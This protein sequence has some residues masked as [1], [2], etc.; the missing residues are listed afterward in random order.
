M[1]SHI[2]KVIE[3]NSFIL[4][5]LRS[6]RKAAQRL[7]RQ[8]LKL[9]CGAIFCFDSSTRV[10]VKKPW[11]LVSTLRP[12]FFVKQRKRIALFKGVKNNW[13][14]TEPIPLKQKEIPDKLLNP[15]M[16]EVEG[17]LPPEI[18]MMYKTVRVFGHFDKP[19]FLSLCKVN[20]YIS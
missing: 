1:F 7:C 4:S 10:K 13:T 11:E 15:D 9:R 6:S 5:L 14:F 20:Y 16:D 2:C 18:N 17:R 19:V 3:R 12:W 8:K